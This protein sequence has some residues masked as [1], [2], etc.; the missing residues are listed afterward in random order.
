MKH[1][2]VVL[3]GE[4]TKWCSGCQQEKQLDEFSKNK[5]RPDGLQNYCKVCAYIAHRKSFKKRQERDPE[6]AKRAK[7]NHSLQELYGIGLDQFNLMLWDQNDHC[8]IC[9]QPMDDPQVDQNRETK[10]IR[11]LLCRTCKFGIGMFGENTELLLRAIS[12]L[13]SYKTS[14]SASRKE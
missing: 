11:A 1:K 14:E 8:A 10:V 5:A 6:A 7:R 4:T 3:E 9:N 13:D 2:S 12:Y